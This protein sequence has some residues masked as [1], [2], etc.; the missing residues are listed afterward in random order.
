MAI[1]IILADD[2]AIFRQGLAQL[3][4]AE[5]GFELVAQVADG[6]A[7]F[8]LI[9]ALQPDVAIL[10]ITMPELSGIEVARKTTYAGY[11]T[12][13][14]LL[15]MH[16]DPSMALEAQEAG[17]AGYVLKDNTFEELVTAVRTVVAG[18]TFMTSSVRD[19]LRDLQSQGYTTI[20]LSR[21]ERDVIKMIALGHSSKEIGRL[22]GISPRTVDTYRTRL[23]GKLDLKT[24][25]DVVRY[26][27]RTGIAS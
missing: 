1:R 23:M 3:L 16:G 7:A 15:T 27:V 13:V 19:R 17:A 20:K 2:H 26:A 11:R 8:E 22:L 4:E 5:P 12:R 9:E 10:D 18:G 24:L 21:R 25:A 14:V 6:R